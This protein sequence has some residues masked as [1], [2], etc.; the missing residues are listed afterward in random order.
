MA[1]TKT[2]RLASIAMLMT[3]SQLAQGEPITKVFYSGYFTGYFSTSDLE[4]ST[5]FVSEGPGIGVKLGRGGYVSGMVI[6]H[7]KESLD[8]GFNLADYPL[9]LYG[10]KDTDDLPPAVAEP[11]VNSLEALKHN[12][13]NPVFDTLNISGATV[14]TACSHRCEAIVVQANQNEQILHLTS[15]GLTQADILALIKGDSNAAE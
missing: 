15:D 14:Y 11:F 3:L 1:G 2:I 7:A 9:Y 10:H 13:K 5:F 8:V 12:L 6:T 4:G